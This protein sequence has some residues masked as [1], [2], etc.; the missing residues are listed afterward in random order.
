MIRTARSTLAAYRDAGTAVGFATTASTTGSPASS[1]VN[2]GGTTY[3]A[4][5]WTSS[6]TWVCGQSGWVDVI[7]VG[8]GGSGASGTTAYGGG[9]GGVLVERFY[10]IA[11]TTYT[12]TVGTGAA[13]D[14]FSNGSPSRF[15]DLIALGGGGGATSATS[16]IT[17]RVG[18]GGG[19]NATSTPS[20]L[21]Q[22]FAGSSSGAG[23]GAGGAASGTT[24]GAGLVTWAGTF[25]A[26]GGTTGA[27]PAA[28]SG[29]GG[30]GANGNGAA[31]AVWL[32]FR[33]S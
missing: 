6:G 25:G 17:D 4:L 16:G 22:G 29:G 12:I 8:G 11:G 15:A 19:G 18:S 5:Q 32:G 27:A 30:T 13:N 28:N 33:R 7:V 14:T 9:G 1:T 20:I 10:A 31:G 3:D 23:G 26:G 2:Y 21:G 24:G